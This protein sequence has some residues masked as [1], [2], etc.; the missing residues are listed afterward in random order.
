MRSVGTCENHA[1]AIPSASCTGTKDCGHRY[2]ST[3][4]LVRYVMLIVIALAL[5]VLQYGGF[6][7]WVT[8]PDLLLAFAAWAMVDG[9]ED[10]MVLRAWLIGLVADMIDPGSICFHS[11]TFLFLA[12]AYLPLRSVIFRTRITGWGAWAMIGSLTCNLIDGW[13]AGFGDATGWSMLVSAL[14]T[15]LAAMGMGWLFRGL[16]KTLQPVGK[17]GA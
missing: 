4:R 1:R 14:W 11:L 3:L 17:G 7:R 6:A 13:V 16:P 5:G 10:S 8:G 12:V 9:T 15:A 2:A